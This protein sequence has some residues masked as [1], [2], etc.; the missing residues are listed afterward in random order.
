MLAE[1]GHG[2]PFEKSSLHF[3]VSTDIA[4][5]IHILKHRAGVSTNAESARYKEFKHDRAYVPADWPEDLRAVLESAARRGFQDYHKVL[6]L[7][8]KGGMCR[9]RAKESARFFLPY[10][11]VLDADV[12]FNFRS[13]V[14][15]VRLRAAPD[16]QA[17]V[18]DVANQMLELVRGTGHFAA[19]YDPRDDVTPWG[20]DDGHGDIWW[21]EYVEC[22]NPFDS[23]HDAWAVTPGWGPVQV[24][25]MDEARAIEA[26]RKI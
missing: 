19:I 14:H 8:V 15:F 21:N 22:T 9:K 10:A 18:R 24:V 4:T 25:N 13:F 26:A 5:H 20:G 3:L 11:T 7:L 17:E 12:M 6:D 1:S 2:T 16:A 23:P